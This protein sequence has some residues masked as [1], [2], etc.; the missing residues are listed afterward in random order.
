MAI[1]LAA[2]PQRGNPRGP[3]A[4]YALAT[5]ALVALVAAVALTARQPAPPDI[6]EFAP[7]ARHQIHQ[8]PLQQTS[9]FGNAPGTASGAPAS[10]TTTSTTP[11]LPGHAPPLT[12]PPATIDIPAIHHCV[13][14]PPRQIA[15]TQSPPC[16]AYWQGNNGGATAPGVTATQINALVN[17]ASLGDENAHRV[18]QDLQLFFNR[19][20]EFYGRQLN[21]IDGSTE[22]GNCPTLESDADGL[23]QTY[24]PFADAGNDN[25]RTCAQLEF[26]RDHVVA[27]G[28]Q[29]IFSQSVMQQYAPYLW[30]Y[31]E[32]PDDEFADTGRFVC[33]QLAGKKA[34][35][36]PTA[37]IASQQRKFGL[38]NEYDQTPD[39]VS[40]AP[41]TQQLASCGVKLAAT[42]TYVDQD[43]S[44]AAQE[45]G[46]IIDFSTDA[47]L[48]MKEA[49][50]T[51][52]LCSCL[53][54][55]EVE[56]GLPV[57]ADNQGYYPEWLL[58]SSEN[59]VDIVVK[60]LWP[61]GDQ[62]DALLG[63]T[64]TP[65]EVPY[66]DAT[67]NWALQAVDPGFQVDDASPVFA[68]YQHFYF[69]MLMLASGI[70][71][72]GPD[73]TPAS[74]QRGLEATDFPNPFSP[75]RE[76]AVDLPG[77][78]HS[79]TT[80]AAVTWWSNNAPSP[81]PDDPLG[82]WCYVD[83]GERFSATNWQTP[84]RFYAG[85]CDASPP[86]S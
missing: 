46:S 81:Y 45:E 56:L 49:G 82:A 85:T 83:G 77:S 39:P 25:Y 27:L 76:G 10:T 50:V 30:E 34:S 22:A 3:G 32:A 71:M 20:F 16:I 36:S 38:I 78:S 75:Q 26:A 24:R 55:D 13:G 61:P 19:Y 7:Q 41:L 42:E 62:R 17:P 1:S 51:T 2:R 40:T 64:F 4:V 8:A 63:L 70:Q 44:N 28:Y 9:N 58:T 66:P 31:P 11:P 5:V 14:N 67:L 73:L 33:A 74:F 79:M 80:D 18:V 57:E 29:D 68:N 6:A 35:L 47:V 48:A 84:M 37:T 23:T 59:D 54:V 15:D 72:A 21:L 43:D 60:T 12:V 69:E 52:V 65:A 86:G 53:N